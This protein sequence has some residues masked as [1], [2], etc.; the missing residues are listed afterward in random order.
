M[1]CL[2]ITDDSYKIH[3]LPFITEFEVDCPF[4]NSESDS[5][6]TPCGS[7]T[8]KDDYA[9]SS[10]TVKDYVADPR[11]GLDKESF[12]ELVRKPAAKLAFVWLT[13]DLYC[14]VGALQPAYP[15]DNV[16]FSALI[17]SAVKP[18][19]LIDAVTRNLGRR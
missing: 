9:T 12:C 16:A 3:E 1:P 7:M 11:S 2:L 10:S 8:V 4:N 17:C 14:I 19:T 15:A 18:T 6:S 5:G 13:L